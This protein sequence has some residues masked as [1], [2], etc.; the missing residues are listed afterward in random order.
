MP[1]AKCRQSG[2]NS[3]TCKSIPQEAIEADMPLEPDANV[4]AEVNSELVVAEPTKSKGKG[5]NK[6]PKETKYYCYILGQSKQL[7]KTYQF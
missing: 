7:Q 3:R 1:C 5:K 6:E 4:V 2:H